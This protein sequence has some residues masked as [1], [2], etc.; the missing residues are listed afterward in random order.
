MKASK[1]LKG[2]LVLIIFNLIGK[3]LGAV[4]RIPL[5]GF[6]GGEGMGQY[7]LT[8]PLYCLILTIATSGI[9]V[10]ISKMVAEFRT[11]NEFSNSKKLLKVSL[12]ILSLLSAILAAG[13]VLLA[14]LV[15]KWQGNPEIYICYYA[16]APAILFVG[17][18]SAFRGYF[19]GNLMMYPTAISGFIEQV[20]KIV[21][22]LFL[23]RK[24]MVYGTEFGVFGAILGVSISEFFACLFL[25]CCFVAYSKKL[26]GE[27]KNQGVV[28][29]SRQI[30]RQLLSVSLPITFGGLIAPLT[31][32]IDSLLVV[33][34]LMF[35]GFS[36][37]ASTMMLGLQ[38][39]VVE[40]LVNIPV[41]IAVSISTALLPSISELAAKKRT[42]EINSLIKKSF[43]I[44]L[45]IA[46]TCF[47]CF[48]IFGKQ[49]LT[50]LYGRSF[51]G[52]ELSI[53]TK[54]LFLGGINI[55]FL[56]LVQVSSGILQGL[57]HQK[58]PVISL[59]FGCMVKVA[60][61]VALILIPSINIFGAAIAAGGCY[62]MVFM[63]NLRKIIKVTGVKLKGVYGHIAV[64]QSCIC[65]FAY[66]LN[67]V[68]LPL[69]QSL[70]LFA[71]GAVTGLI[72]LVTFYLMFFQERN[73][74]T[75]A[76]KEQLEP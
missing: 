16:I 48:I 5:A 70:A 68:F 75:V 47:V 69:G 46:A 22:G 18:L 14:K 73:L 11:K 44:S 10:A 26:G 39:G 33:N 51:G 4:Y 49:M 54:L 50:F 43:E 45:S 53:A 65:L 42:D 71:A 62:L 58:Y 61:D 67:K 7:Q 19:Q 57:S 52:Y 28:L 23:A 35:D 13:I 59:L 66:F 60:L 15:S 36:S 64:Q 55:I 32:M 21:I 3:V 6:L 29:A 38:S 8:F 34:L 63:L 2:T 72:F 40:P 31:A 41:I 37:A 74:K 30:S 12:L 1:F 25:V 56:S 20:V 76:I 27:G 9:P 24:F 17:V